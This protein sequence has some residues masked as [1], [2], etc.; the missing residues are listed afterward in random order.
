M[1]HPSF[2]ELQRQVEETIADWSHQAAELRRSAEELL[3]D[4]VIAARKIIRAIRCNLTS[5]GGSSRRA[6][7]R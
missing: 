4:E 3:H 5:T 7:G 1:K 6:G 2:A